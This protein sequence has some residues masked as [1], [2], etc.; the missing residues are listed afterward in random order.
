MRVNATRRWLGGLGVGLALAGAGA[1]VFWIP[2]Q[3]EVS[4][5]LTRVVADAGTNPAA[6]VGGEEIATWHAERK[7]FEG[8]RARAEQRAART[9]HELSA[10]RS[11][12][13]Q[14]EHQQEALSRDS[15]QQTSAGL[16]G[17]PGTPSGAEAAAPARTPQEAL[18]REAAHTQ[19]QVEFLDQ[20]LDAEE[21]DPAWAEAAQHALDEAFRHEQMRGLTLVEHECRTT[22]CRLELHL[23]G[24]MS[25]AQTFHHLAQYAQWRGA[26]FVRIDNAGSAVVY[27]V[28]EGHTFP[29]PQ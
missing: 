18:E 1:T 26:G 10:L 28:R 11:R 21:T 7:R 27:L 13:T 9:H 24:S 2:A 8:E 14:L 6:R 16:T 19:A 12:L 5:E 25:P 17:A 4:Q 3:R 29:Q 15:A 20:S 23:D 22:M